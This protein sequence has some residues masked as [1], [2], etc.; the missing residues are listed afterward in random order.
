MINKK[1]NLMHVALYK[2]IDS[3]E[4][5]PMFPIYIPQVLPQKSFDSVINIFTSEISLTGRIYSG[6][7]AYSSNHESRDDSRKEFLEWLENQSSSIEKD[8]SKLIKSSTLII[9]EAYKILPIALELRNIWKSRFPCHVNT[10]I[11][12]SSSTSDA[13]PLHQ[14]P[15]H[16]FVL[17]LFGKKRWLFSDIQDDETIKNSPRIISEMVSESG[18]I[19]FIPKGVP[20]QARAIETS[21]HVSISVEE[22]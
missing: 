22:K 8:Y 19:I 13:F 3:I 20:H 11:Y 9:R 21:V 6:F 5:W 7:Q 10:N 4:K 14:D 18:D 2:A 15:H 17:Q 1:I 12:I 16:V